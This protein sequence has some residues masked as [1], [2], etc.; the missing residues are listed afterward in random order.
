M[1]IKREFVNE[2]DAY[3]LISLQQLQ[4]TLLLLILLLLLLLPYYYY[5]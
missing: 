2:I 4:E 3:D 5:N 1:A